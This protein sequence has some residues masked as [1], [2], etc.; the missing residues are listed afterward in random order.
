[1]DEL[2]AQFLIEGPELIQ[3]GSD[4]LFAL[5]RAPEDRRSLD[6]AFRALHTLKGSAGL[7][8]MLPLETMLHAAEDVLDAVRQGRRPATPGMLNGLLAILTQT[9][10]WL[11]ALQETE[12]LPP[13]A[14]DAADA[15]IRSLVDPAA[16]SPPAETV[17]LTAIRY[18]PDPKCYF[19]GDDPIQLM[20]AVPK[21]LELKIGL[22]PRADGDAPYDPFTC[23]LTLDA[24]S[25]ATPDELK[26]VFRFVLDQV[27]LTPVEPASSGGE[28]MTSPDPALRT[29]RVDV[30]KLEGLAGLIDELVTV[31][32]GVAGIVEAARRGIAPHTLTSD[33]AAQYGLLD[34]LVGR[35]HQSVSGLRMVPV[36]PFLRRFP[37]LVRE[38]A[39]P[40]G[41]EIDITIENNAVEADKEVIERLFEP[42][43]HLLRNA[44]DHGVETVEQRLAAGK[45]ARASISLGAEV[46]A[47]RL[48]LRLRDDGCGIDPAHIR[49][50]A[51]KRGLLPA[52][53]LQELSDQEAIEL[54]F[55]PGFSTAQAVSALSGRGV[56]MDAV[57]AAVQRLGGRVA[58]SSRMGAG[59]TIELILPLSVSLTKVIIVTTG[60]QNYGVPMDRVLETVRISD[61][62]VVP[63]RAGEAFN[64][65][66]RTVPLL[67]LSALTG[68]AAMARKGARKVLVIRAQDQPIGIAIDGI[69]GRL[70]VAMRPADGL[71]AAMPG[72]A[73][74]TMLGDGRVL[75]IL[76]PEALVA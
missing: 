72:L 62:Q 70:D 16:V 69:V 28:G 54:I 40:L 67:A 34:R 37:R 65:R 57:Q 12:R 33:L 66:E 2:L 59:T 25:A 27:V 21:L 64:W 43:T 7:F 47:G 5:E 3:Q 42:L 68:G 35:V 17:A 63:I 38:M 55:L 9:E 8:D 13:G 18:R 73:G 53:R 46:R 44:V 71:L 41:R 23:A 26:T 60:E 6:D 76:D 1:M 20:R 51:E 10:R 4:A 30:E 22:Q 52:E 56:G 31:K 50:T 19:R 11:E 14:A 75:L 58:L 15:L 32:N 49:A 48:R 74:T 45:P 61:S 36:T 24:V 39:A 29:L